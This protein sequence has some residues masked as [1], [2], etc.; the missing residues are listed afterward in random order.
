MLCVLMYTVVLQ[1]SL[2]LYLRFAIG[3]LDES[4]LD[5]LVED[6]QSVQTKWEAIGRWLYIRE[7]TLEDIRTL[8]SHTR[9]GDVL[10]EVFRNWLP[11]F[12]HNVV[13][14]LRSVGEEH[15]AS[16]LKV[17]YGELSTTDSSLI[18]IDAEFSLNT[19]D[20]SGPILLLAC[21]S[22]DSCCM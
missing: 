15:L 21:D 11:N 6:L 7:E 18:C 10:R 9:P 17:K 1:W 13:R 3:V 2:L 20:T 16:E 8:Y 5:L 14:A 19:V 12:W 4:D 22:M